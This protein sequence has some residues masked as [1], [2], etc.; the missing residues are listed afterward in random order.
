MTTKRSEKPLGAT[1]SGSRPAA[2]PLGSALSRAAARSLAMARRESED[3]LRFQV[4]SIVDGSRVNL[5][6]LAEQ[7][8]ENRTRT[9]A[10]KLAV[11]QIASEVRLDCNGER[12]A[13]CLVMRIRMARE[14]VG[15]A[16]S[17]EIIP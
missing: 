15:W 3:Q 5:D 1:D 2:Y 14:G 13:D 11:P 9:D 17:P 6:G 10:A 4:V 16:E 7:I 12:R 8:R